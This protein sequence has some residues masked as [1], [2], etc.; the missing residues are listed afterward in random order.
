MGPL[1]LEQAFLLLLFFLPGYFLVNAAFPRP[2]SF[3]GDLDPL[4]RVFVG[5]LAS[6]ALAILYGTVLVIAGQARGAVLFLPETLWGGLA[7]L[8]ALL[9]VLGALRGAYPRLRRW[10]GLPA[11][12]AA[13]S[14]EEDTSLD[15]LVELA[16]ELEELERA[17]REARGEEAERLARRVEE[18]T[19]EKR[20]LEERATERM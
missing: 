3:G 13:P 19:A 16:A 2:R 4:Y 10:V 9:F 12:E 5:V 1:A 6:V 7:V 18:I 17:H 11:P 8:T 20:L 14:E 15:R